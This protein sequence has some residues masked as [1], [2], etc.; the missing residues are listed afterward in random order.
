MRSESMYLSVPLHAKVKIIFISKV[1]KSEFIL[2]GLVFL[3][4]HT[5][6]HF[7]YFGGH[8]AWFYQTV[9]TAKK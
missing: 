6:S 2:S 1:I 9:F 3:Q 5:F 8:K 4:L 7:Y